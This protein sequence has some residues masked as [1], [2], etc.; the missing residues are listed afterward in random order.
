MIDYSQPD[1]YR[2]NEDSFR[3]VKL[4]LSKVTHSGHILDLGAGSGVIGIELARILKPHVLTLVEAQ[5][6]YLDHQ[7]K[8]CDLLLSTEIKIEFE[9]KKFS[10]WIPA[11]RYDLIISNPPYYLPGHGE[12][13]LDPRKE[14]ARS[15][16]L[17][18]WQMLLNKI[19]EA[20]SDNG[21]AYLVVRNDKRII[22]EISKDTSLEKKIQPD[23]NL[24]FIEL[25]RLN[26]N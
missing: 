18:N 16:I 24:L 7:K 10:E 21:K 23:K 1:F 3:L 15:F 20:L 25:S 22:Q 9:V 13:N 17:D 11:R 26:K 12:R 8:N 5:D 19:F 6:G 2:F 4:V 14:M